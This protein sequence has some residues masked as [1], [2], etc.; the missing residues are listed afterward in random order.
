VGTVE[1]IPGL[2]FLR[3][4]IGH[5]YLWHGDGRLTLIETSGPGLL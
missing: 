3:F 5:A 1:L 4:P 2:P